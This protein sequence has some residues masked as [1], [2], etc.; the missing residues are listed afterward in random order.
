MWLLFLKQPPGDGTRF[1]YLHVDLARHAMRHSARVRRPSTKYRLQT[2]YCRGIVALVRVLRRRDAKA[3][4][5]YC[6][7]SQCTSPDYQAYCSRT[8]C[9]GSEGGWV[10]S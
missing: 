8:P 1:T 9:V 6:C 7:R 3:A 2:L 5:K 10:S 4:S